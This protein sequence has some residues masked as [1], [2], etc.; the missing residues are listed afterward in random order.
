MVAEESIL[1]GKSK[2]H[3]PFNED[4]IRRL[5]EV[6]AEVGCFGHVGV[7][8]YFGEMKWSDLKIPENVESDKPSLGSGGLLDTL[9]PAIFRWI[10]ERERETRVQCVRI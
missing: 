8:T 5:D 2:V 6:L 7:S 9:Q 1:A 3:A 10:R 4:Q